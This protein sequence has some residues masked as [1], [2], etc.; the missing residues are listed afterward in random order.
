VVKVRGA[1]ADV[2]APEI[3]VATTPTALAELAAAE[4]VQCALTAVRERGRF[5]VALAGGS[6]PLLLYRLLARRGHL[7]SPGALPW[8]QIH[9]FWG[10]ER[11]VPPT[12]ADSNYGAAKAALLDA[13]AIPPQNIHRI[14][15]EQP[16]AASLYEAEVRAFFGLSAGDWP[17]FDLVL[18]GIGADGHTA[19]LFPGS[20]ALGER[21]RIVVANPIA[22][23]ATTRITLTL[24]AINAAAR[25]VFLV[26]G[27][28]K[29]ATV[30]R[31]LL[32]SQ[33][34]ERLPA[35]DVRPTSGRLLWLLDAAAASQLPTDRV[36]AR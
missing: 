12:H 20:P 1:V 14:R 10:D 6:T 32:P 2:P 28:E 26:A 7:V 13:V 11:R 24:P 35:Q 30:A 23:L 34:P 16:D 3:R 25:V 8:R 27:A 15:A 33:G 29:A 18:L 4:F 5:S 22:D 36:G 31:I 9:L 17:R 21:S 19:S